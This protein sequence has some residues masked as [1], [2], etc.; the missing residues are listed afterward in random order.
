MSTSNNNYIDNSNTTDTDSNDNS[1]DN[2]TNDDDKD[3]LEEVLPVD[4]A[5]QQWKQPTQTDIHVLTNA[6]PPIH[7]LFLLQCHW[8]TKARA[9]T[10]DYVILLPISMR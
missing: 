6:I 5:C 3:V 2:N 7:F 10:M 9:H 8:D 1:C 4:I